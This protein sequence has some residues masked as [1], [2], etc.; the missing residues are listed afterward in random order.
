MNE[1]KLDNKFKLLYRFYDIVSPDQS[2]KM[3]EFV[4]NMS[5]EEKEDFMKR[6]ESDRLYTIQSPMNCAS[7]EDL[8]RLYKE[9]HPEPQK[10]YYINEY[11]EKVPSIR[12]VIVA[13]EYIMRLKQEPIT[14]FSVRSK[15]M[16]NPRTAMPI[17]SSLA[18]HRRKIY[19]DQCNRL[20]ENLPVS[21]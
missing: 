16:T 15:S 7:G 11:G 8:A 6:T 1:D 14:K 5:H 20:G 17:R 21:I 4:G 3:K 2:E 18:A 19:S 10:I 13:D 9:F 12:D